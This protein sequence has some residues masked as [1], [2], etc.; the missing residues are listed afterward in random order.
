MERMRGVQHA[1]SI[2]EVMRR[3][4]VWI[5]IAVGVALVN[6]I[7]VRAQ[8]LVESPIA[9]YS[10]SLTIGGSLT[11]VSEFYTASGIAQRQPGFIQRFSGNLSANLFGIRS[12]LSVLF[13]TEDNRFRQS[14]NAV[15]FQGRYHW[16]G[17][18]AGM[19]YPAFSPLIAGGIQLLGG[20]LTIDPAPLNV[21]LIIG[22][23]RR[24]IEGD[25]A[26][27][28][29]GVFRQ[30]LYGGS[31]GWQFADGTQLR[32]Q[33]LYAEDDPQSIQQRAGATPQRNA[34]T[35]LQWTASLFNRLMVDL[36]AAASVFQ[37]DVE[38]DTIAI[39][40]LPQFVRNIFPPNLALTLGY[41][42]RGNL[43]FQLAPVTA[44]AFVRYVSPAFVSFA[45]GT[46]LNDLVEV[47]FNP[48]VTFDRW[49]LNA[50]VMVSEDNLLGAKVR[51]SRLR[52]LAIFGNW[53]VS[54][55]ILLSAVGSWYRQ[56]V[57][58][59]YQ[60]DSL[61]IP[62]TRS[63][64]WNASVTT[65]WSYR[66]IGLPMSSVVTVQYQTVDLTI[67]EIPS[68]AGTQYNAT[69][70]CSQS[71][72]L[73]AHSVV[74]GVGVNWTNQMRNWFGN[75]SWNMPLPIGKQVSQL[76]MTV[77]GY[78]GSGGTS[79]S[80]NVSAMV[81]WNYPLWRFLTLTLN[82]RTQWVQSTQTYWELVG[83]V[84]LTA[85]L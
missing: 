48:S 72:S 81:T 31:I 76:T 19:I 22:R 84:G 75:L 74:L 83:N 2:S 85:S 33:G 73:G 46:Q 12:G 41:A 18:S 32:L 44:T 70:N 47:R 53:V 80:R 4:L 69:V 3:L 61:P 82:G 25:T 58:P 42:V 13:S 78:Y 45:L 1:A 8:T 10:E 50:D 6:Q 68:G 77:S 40:E 51:T 15:Q 55:A 23:S 30:M 60:V 62:K 35:A 38:S 11:A 59:N 34:V 14:L 54:D 79:S 56:Q 26:A 43:S 5:G 39:E 9:G 29:K 64:V 16:I 27:N 49:S 17:L 71:L 28:R 66:L 37:R 7:A 21:Q 36:E 57:D 20:Q 63:D 65:S 67:N 24:A 52:S